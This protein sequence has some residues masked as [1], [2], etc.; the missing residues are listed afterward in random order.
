MRRARTTIQKEQR[1]QALLDTTWLLF[2][3]AG[4]EAVTVAEVAERAGLAKGTVYLYVKTKEELF[5]AVLTQ[6]L[7]EWFGDLD[8]RLQEAE[9]AAPAAHI[10]ALIA[11]T[12]L[13]RAALARL[14]PLLSLLEQNVALEAER[15]FKQFL[16]VHL[17]ATGALLEQR[18]PTLTP[19]VGAQLLLQIYAFMIGLRSLAEPT[20][21]AQQALQDA[22]ME[23]FVVD[24][25]TMLSQT[26][27]T[28]LR[29]LAQHNTGDS[30]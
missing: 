5:L 28:L 25:S 6:Q 13:E 23:L 22:G 3:E 8:R 24:F 19:G 15:G 11:E 9:D 4:Y 29:G 7:E 12:L 30:L 21:V 17:L 26:I 20:P 16:R 14:L 2:Q 10:A 1:R 18:L 27:H